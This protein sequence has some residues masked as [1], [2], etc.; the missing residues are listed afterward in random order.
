MRRK[1]R[2]NRKHTVCLPRGYVTFVCDNGTLEI[3]HAPERPKWRCPFSLQGSPMRSSKRAFTLVELLVVIAIIGIL[4]A[5]LL[6]AVQAARGAA[7]RVQCQNRIRQNLL[8]VHM[9]HDST[10]V[11]PPANIVS[12]SWYQTTWFGEV[13]YST[14]MVAKHKGLIS[15]FIEGNA[16]VQHCPYFNEGRVRLLYGGSNG[17]YGYNMNLG[18][19]EWLFESSGWNQVQRLKRLADFPSTSGTLVMADSA[20]IQ[21][22]YGSDTETI[23]TENFYLL[24]PDDPWA[25]PGIQFRHLGRVAN[26]GFLDGHVSS[27]P[28]DFV[29]SPSWWPADAVQLRD[30]LA[31]GY[32]KK[33]S[34]DLY[35]PW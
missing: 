7:V 15:P 29:P 18:Q 10:R 25:F 30:E 8:A 4:V 5:L 19:V 24:G 26:I 23:A 34:V 33:R 20:R 27:M 22:P 2:I 13:D 6:P 3:N 31:I 17:G 35:R 1:E 14:S 9:Y 11:L 21:L 28:E 32:A 12:N 16:Q